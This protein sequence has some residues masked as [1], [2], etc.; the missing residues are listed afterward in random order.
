ME[1]DFFCLHFQKLF[2]L[3]KDQYVIFNELNNSWHGKHKVP[4]L[5]ATLI[6]EGIRSSLILPISIRELSIGFLFI[7][8]IDKNIFTSSTNKY[9]EIFFILEAIIQKAM[10]S[11]DHFPDSTV[12]DAWK[13][14]SRVAPECIE[15]NSAGKLIEMR[16][17]KL[18]FLVPSFVTVPTTEKYILTN[19]SSLLRV[20]TECRFLIEVTEDTSPYTMTCCVEEGELTV[21]VSNHKINRWRQEP[22]N[23]I[24][25]M[26]QCDISGI[27]CFEEGDALLFTVPY[28]SRE[29]KFSSDE[30][31]SVH[32]NIK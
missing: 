21:S 14:V 4:K 8:S 27:S 13:L 11:F 9:T 7:N 2:Y 10:F 3:K 25:L 22:C 30:A 20:L 12:M 5:F 19:L 32:E 16:L 23:L 28:E 29:N 24:R 31:Y 15:A 18:G 6:D 17:R 1:Q 26:K